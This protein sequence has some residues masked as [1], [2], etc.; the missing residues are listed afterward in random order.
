MASP[1]LLN[2]LTPLGCRCLGGDYIGPAVGII[3]CCS[4]ESYTLPTVGP[5]Y[6]LGGTM[7]DTEVKL[8]TGDERA[9]LAADYLGEFEHHRHRGVND[10][11][12]ELVFFGNDGY[13]QDERSRYEVEKLREMLAEEELEVRGFGLSDG[14]YTWALICDAPRLFTPEQAATLPQGK[15]ITRNLK[16]ATR[17]RNALVDRLTQ[18]LYKAW[19]EATEK[20]RG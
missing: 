9:K 15:D 8:L 20:Y 14:G 7:S 1:D 4:P 13:E 3:V 11:N 6:L 12:H 10:Y 2:K 18:G 16:V 19:D 17:L 5:S